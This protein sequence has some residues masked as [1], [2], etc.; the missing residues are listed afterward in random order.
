MDYQ[1][2]GPM[3]AWIVI[4]AVILGVFGSRII[5]IYKLRSMDFAWY[6]ATHPNAVRHNRV[7][8]FRCDNDRIHV[9]ALLQRTFLR[10]HF[11]TQCGTALYYSREQRI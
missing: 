6:R 10:E 7:V 2:F 11:C 3:A 5:R 8:C 1:K 4:G 9:R